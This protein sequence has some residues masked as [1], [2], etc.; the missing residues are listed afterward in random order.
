MNDEMERLKKA[1]R[2]TKLLPSV[3]SQKQA[4]AV[5][6]SAFERH[7]KGIRE[8][9]RQKEYVAENAISWPTHDGRNQELTMSDER[10]VEIERQIGGLMA[11][12]NA[13]RKNRPG[14]PVPNYTFETLTGQATLHDLFGGYDKLLAIHNMGQGC[15]YC[16]LW[17]D[18][19]NGLLAHLES[20]LSVVLLSKDPP[21]VQRRFANARGWR[22]R[23]ASHGGR[24]YMDEQSVVEGQQNYPGAVVYQRQGDIILRQNACVFGPGD[25]YC[26]MWGLLGLAGLGEEEWTPQFAYWSRP[27][28]LDDGGSDVL[29]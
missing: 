16:T 20:T 26:S 1:L 15:R 22:F 3:E 21:A 6:T 10:I 7:H 4:I 24:A 12:L 13:L 29:V 17:A 28:T 5:A 14:T 8:E 2:A 18:G 27:E 9:A 19:F 23:L 25:L 11:E